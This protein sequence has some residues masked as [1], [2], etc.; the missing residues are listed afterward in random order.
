MYRQASVG[1]VANA[2]CKYP[3]SFKYAFKTNN[4]YILTFQ[5]ISRLYILML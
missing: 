4:L 1:P 3:S 2:E 5:V